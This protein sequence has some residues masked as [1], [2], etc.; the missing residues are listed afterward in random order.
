MN[1]VKLFLAPDRRT[2][3]HRHH[4]LGGQVGGQT[5]HK[6]REDQG[7]SQSALH[8]EE[9]VQH[10]SQMVFDMQA[11]M[12]DMASNLR[13]DFQEDASKMLVTLL[14]NYKQPVSARGAETESI[15]VQDFSFDHETLPVDEVMNKISKVT[16]DLEAKS[17][18]LDDLLGRV[19]LHDGQIRSLMGASETPLAMPPPAG[20][21]SD[22]DLRA[23]LDDKIRALREELMEGMDIKMADL[24]NS[25][26]YKILSVQEQC[27]GQEVN[28]LSLAELMDSKESDLRKEM[29]DLKAKLTDQCKL[30]T[31]GSD[32]VLARMN[33]LEV[34]L[35][36]SQGTLVAKCLSV[37]ER[38]QSKQE[39]AVRELRQTMEGRL[40]SMQDKLTTFLVEAGTSSPSGDQ[41]E[42]PDALQNDISSLKDS[43]RSLEH[44]L[45][46]VDPLC[47]REC[48]AN[49]TALEN[50]QQDFQSFRTIVDAKETQIRA[51]ISDIRAMEG[52]LFNHSSSIEN[53]NANLSYLN[54]YVRR[55]E[56][57]LSGAVQLQP[58]LLKSLNSSW[59][60]V[61]ENA[62][63][64][65]KVLL[66]FHREQHQKLRKQ[67]DDLGREV[68]AEADQCREKTQHIGGEVAHMDSR[69]VNVE[70]LCSKLDPI[71]ESLWRIKDGLNKHV[72]GLW[73][74]VNQ[75]NVT[76]RAHARD[77]GGLK[78]TYQTLQNGKEGKPSYVNI[79]IASPIQ[80]KYQT[81]QTNSAAI[82]TNYC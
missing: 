16:H 46:S 51:Q 60:K 21:A 52:Q 17:N 58:Q 2:E 23:Y 1:F 10:L 9:E 47:S 44:R 63:Q 5:D 72:T 57:S 39:E 71:S 68:K 74:C 70:T 20:P 78:G 37:E 41:N 49:L 59:S 73:T 15:R 54:G 28:Y 56:D 81:Y 27:E 45:D 29:E 80:Q 76:V 4:P 69:I 30:D 22:A 33:N 67:L 3:N 62:Q 48:K 61:N 32:S 38:L 24:K 40:A 18:A 31:Q 8:L 19:N 79:Y 7:G 26:D 77:I 75:L 12:T 65:A 42:G 64:E 6:P 66:E 55:V 14:N 13:L 25:C 43:V 82:K 11:R 35:N 53:I 50:L 34:H 36:S